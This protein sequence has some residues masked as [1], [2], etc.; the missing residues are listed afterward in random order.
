[1]CAI[2]SGGRLVVLEERTPRNWDSEFPACVSI[3]PLTLQVKLEKG[4]PKFGCSELCGELP[5]Q[6]AVRVQPGRAHTSTN[7]TRLALGPLEMGVLCCA[8]GLFAFF[9]FNL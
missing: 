5:Y 2:P 8:L 9:I 3:F 4:G 6:G 7:P 1:M